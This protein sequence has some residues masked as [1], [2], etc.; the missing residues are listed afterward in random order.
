VV[1]YRVLVGT[2]N[3]W[4]DTRHVFTLFLPLR[5]QNDVLLFPCENQLI[6]SAINFLFV[7]STNKILTASL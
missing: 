6:I 5:L 4:R 3:V 2:W 7:M 1:V